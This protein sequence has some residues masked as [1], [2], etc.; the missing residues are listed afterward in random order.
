MDKI[1]KTE[2]AWREHLAQKNAEPLAY[3]VTRQAA[4]E[5]P[6]TGR[7]EGHWAPGIY[8]CIC[9]DAGTVN[10]ATNNS[11]VIDFVI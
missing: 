6:F 10:T 3:A 7:Y 11:K 5:R 9:C 8:R 2:A 1:T 4:T